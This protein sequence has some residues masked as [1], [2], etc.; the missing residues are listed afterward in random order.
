MVGIK[1]IEIWKLEIVKRDF[2]SKKEFLN[3]EKS[4]RCLTII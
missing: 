1:K 3:L 4:N 2:W